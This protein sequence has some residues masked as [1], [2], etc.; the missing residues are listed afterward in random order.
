M[1]GF[2]DV[3]HHFNPPGSG[4]GQP[5]WSPERALAEMDAAGVAR[6]IG[7]P[8]PV[9]AAS[10]EA[11]RTR[12]REVNEY[13]AALVRRHPAR[14]GLFASLP[15]L[16]DT[17]GALAEIAHAFDVLQ[18]DGI[19][20]VTHYGERWLGDPAFTPVL[21]ELDRRGALV[22][23]HPQGHGAG[24]DCGM[25]GYQTG[26]V[27]AP[28]LEYPFNTARCILNLMASGSLRARPRIRFIF[29]HGGGALTAL[30]GRIEGFSGWNDFGPE[31]LDALFPEGVAAEFGRLHFECAQA[32]TPEAMTLLRARVADTQILFGTD[33]DRFPLTHSVER[34]ARLDL[35][36]ATRDAIASGNALRLLER[37]SST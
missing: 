16:A 6:A 7:W 37:P 19:G 1:S 9:Q 27:S 17:E 15:P 34:F 12:A 11:A 33:Y 18:A 2:V 35:P 30:L 10:V 28:W 24:C 31:R 14:F 13:G 5:G 3:H 36:P 32:Y 23:V 29:C 20:L 22:F 25:L 4:G 8:G 21:D 26:G